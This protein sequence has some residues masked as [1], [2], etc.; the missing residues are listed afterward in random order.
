MSRAD[1]GGRVDFAVD[2]DN[3]SEGQ[4]LDGGAGRGFTAPA[5][6]DLPTIKHLLRRGLIP[7]SKVS[8]DAVELSGEF[9]RVFVSGECV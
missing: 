2:C 1:D 9:L 7:G 6:F 8:K 4:R 3:D 5:S